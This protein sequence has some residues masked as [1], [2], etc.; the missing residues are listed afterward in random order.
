MGLW[1]GGLFSFF[2]NWSIVA[3]QCCVN[4]Y[5]RAKWI[6]CM[7]PSIPSFS[8][9]LPIKVAT[10]HG[11]EPL[12]ESAGSHHLSLLHTAVYVNPSLRNRVLYPR[13]TKAF[14]CFPHSVTSL[15]TLQVHLT[16]H[17]QTLYSFS[18][19]L[20]FILGWKWGGKCGDLRI[21]VI[22]NL[23]VLLEVV[24]WKRRYN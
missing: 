21:P 12:C 5:C 23:L 22:S 13:V 16:R 6:C 15:C 17:F 2:F 18:P 7:Y 19:E 20:A 14:A 8:D 11:V 4:V 10:E 9:F 24:C 1:N 3:L